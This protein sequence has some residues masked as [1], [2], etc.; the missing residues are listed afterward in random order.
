MA[1]I[2][3]ERVSES[4]KI[5]IPAKVGGYIALT[6]PRIIELL[7]VTTVPTMILAKNGMPSVGLII[8]TVVGGTLAAGGANAANMV[9]DRDIDA[10][11]KRTKG[12]PLVTGVVSVVGALVFSVALEIAAFALLA[13]SVNLL[14]AFLALGAT[15]FYVFVYTLML[16]RHSTQNIVIG[17]AAGA[18]PVL[19]GWSAVNDNLKLTPVL[20]ALVIFLWTPPHFWALA[21]KYKDDYAAAKVPMLP[22]VKSLRRTGI[23]ILVY[24]VAVVILSVLL[25]PGSHLSWIYGISA[26]VLGVGFLLLA[27]R[28][29]QKPT[30]KVAMNL[31]KYS[32]TYLTVLFGAIALDILVH[33][34]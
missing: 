11:M 7:L 24:T 16:K 28:L 27:I 18:V 33:H 29:L 21:V 22:S 30:P 5:K 20:L 12:R 8:L 31:F 25:I 3:F 15:L 2:A 9:A 32:I 19:V 13:L 23:E 4:E 17:G 1:S 14:S 34:P 6:K 10:I 26:S